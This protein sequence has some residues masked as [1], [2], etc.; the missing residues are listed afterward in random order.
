MQKMSHSQKPQMFPFVK[1]G[2]KVNFSPNKA[3]NGGS[4]HV[5][6]AEF[7]AQISLRNS[8]HWLQ[9]SLVTR[10]PEALQTRPPTL[11]ELRGRTA[12]QIMSQLLYPHS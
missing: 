12:A 8:R 7:I 4:S 3:T 5:L 9:P 10:K 1:W 6:Q 11:A 2:A